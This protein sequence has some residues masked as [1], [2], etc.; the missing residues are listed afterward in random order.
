M[1]EYLSPGVYAEEIST[2]PVPIEGVSTST[3]GIVGPTARGPLHPRLVTSWLEFQLWYGGLTEL[4]ASSVFATSTGKG[5]AYTTWAAKGF[6]DNGG[7][8]L[9]M[10][11]IVGD[12]A[13][14]PLPNPPPKPPSPA[15][16]DLKAGNTTIMTIESAGS[17]DLTNQ[18]FVRV[19]DPTLRDP[20]DPTKPDPTRR[21]IS[22]LLYDVA[23]PVPLVDPLSLQSAD[24][25]NANRREPSAVEDYDNLQAGDIAVALSGSTLIAPP[26]FA[27]GQQPVLPDTLPFTA[28]AAGS[29]GYALVDQNYIGD[30]TLPLDQ[31]TGLT[32]LAAIDEVSLLCVPDEVLDATGTITGELRIQCELLKDRFAIL[33]VP[34]T[35]QNAHP[36]NVLP[37]FASSY[38][39]TYYPYIRVVDPLTQATMLIPPGGHI[40]GIYAATD[41]ARGVHK[42]PA[43]VEVAGILVNDL[44]GNIKPLQY[45]ISKGDQDILNPRGINA[46]RDFRASGLGIRVWGAR[47]L[48]SDAQWK[49]VNVRRLFIFVEQSV[50]RGTQWV[51]FEP[52]DEFTWS[53]VR[54]SIS[55]FLTSVWRSGALVGATPDEAFFV[56]CDATTMTQDDIDNGRLICLVGMAPAKPAEFVIFRFSQITGQPTS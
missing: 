48:S 56:R 12:I 53:R 38:A 52:N 36:E 43:N 29:Y 1:P 21:R 49:Y 45:T 6:F 32:A 41:D 51:V 46:I 2:G 34:D 20:A 14:N 7:Q 18:I 55:N 13:P 25:R 31:R 22:L 15:S 19:A 10:A 39:A 50:I 23:P 28:L 9:Y 16:L 33:Q 26:A 44:P 11:R 42:A 37:P 40:A 4:G 27:Q 24:L 3:T 35:P 30:E 8:R 47:T 5:F 17:A 54:R